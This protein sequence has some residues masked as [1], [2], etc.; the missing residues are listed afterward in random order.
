MAVTTDQIAQVRRMVAEPTSDT[1]SDDA[2]RTAIAARA[3]RDSRGIE[4]TYLDFTTDPPTYT[5]NPS[6]IETYDLNAVAADIWNEKAAAVACGHD[7][8]ADGASYS[9]SQRFAQYS[10]MAQ[11]YNS[12]R[13]PGSL[14][15]VSSQRELVASEGG[16]SVVETTPIIDRYNDDGVFNN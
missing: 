14:R 11:K 4:P 7:F 3:C 12:R 6:W 8:S 1:Y 16:Y 2:F 9:L 10:K 15:G 13:R 5:T